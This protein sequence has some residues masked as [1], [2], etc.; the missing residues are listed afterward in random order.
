[1]TLKKLTKVIHKCR[2]SRQ[3]FDFYQGYVLGEARLAPVNEA[4]SCLG[5]RRVG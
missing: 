3:A 5:M 4:D 1:M 2:L